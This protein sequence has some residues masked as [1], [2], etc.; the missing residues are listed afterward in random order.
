MQQASCSPADPGGGA[1]GPS[2]AEAGAAGDDDEVDDITDEVMQEALQQ[3]ERQCCKIQQHEQGYN[4]VQQDA[5]QFAG[6]G[7]VWAK[8]NPLLFPVTFHSSVSQTERQMHAMKWYRGANLGAWPAIA[9]L[10]KGKSQS[11]NP[12]AHLKPA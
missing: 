12:A 7:T 11:L 9:T 8:C 3:Y 4:G 1:S 5:G 10:L 2:P 6:G